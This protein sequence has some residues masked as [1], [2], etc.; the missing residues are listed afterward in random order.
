MIIGSQHSLPL[1]RV[2]RS[3]NEGYQGRWESWTGTP[4]Q[5]VD[6]AARARDPESRWWFTHLLAFGAGAALMIGWLTR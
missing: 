2:R 3:L 4:R 5:L 6:L 1:R